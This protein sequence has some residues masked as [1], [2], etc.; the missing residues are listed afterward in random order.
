MHGHKASDII[1][2]TSSF[3]VVEHDGDD[4]ATYAWPIR[5]QDTHHH[6]LMVVEH[7]WWGW[8]HMHGHKASGHRHIDMAMAH[9]DTMAA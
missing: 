3:M 6:M 4:G 8:I 9:Q 2:S 7:A 1:A 5:H